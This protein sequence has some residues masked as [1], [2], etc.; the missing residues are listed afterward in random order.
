MAE[1]GA[2]RW[3]AALGASAG[4]LGVPLA[5]ERRPERKLMRA[6]RSHLSRARRVESPR[7]GLELPWRPGGGARNGARQGRAVFSRRDLSANASNRFGPLRSLTR[8]DS[9]CERSVVHVQGR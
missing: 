5:A 8:R 9:C 1:L 4:W 7:R 6:R 3:G 2:Q